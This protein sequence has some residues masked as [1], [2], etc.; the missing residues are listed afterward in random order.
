MSGCEAGTC[1]RYSAKKGRSGTV[2]PDELVPISLIYFFSYFEDKKQGQYR[3]IENDYVIRSPFMKT[4]SKNTIAYISSGA[5]TG[6]PGESGF[7]ESRTQGHVLDK[8]KALME[9]SVSSIKN[10]KKPSRD[11]GHGS[12]SGTSFG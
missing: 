1:P 12:S 6:G 4:S 8:T 2:Q 10:S 7:E 3:G 11:R 9:L 5:S